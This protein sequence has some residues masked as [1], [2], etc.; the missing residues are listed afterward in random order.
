MK[1]FA[2]HLPHS[3]TLVGIFVVALIGFFSFSYDKDFQ[4][5]ITIA[6]AN[7]YV[8]W[9]IVHHAI[10]KDLYLETVVEYLVYA[11]LGVVIVLS[12]IFRS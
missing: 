4:A 1:K 10:H 6:A 12:T 9:G 5:A 11:A 2:N 8:S 3:V 7:G